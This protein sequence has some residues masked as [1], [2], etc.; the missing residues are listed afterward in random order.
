MGNCWYHHIIF[1]FVTVKWYQMKHLAVLASNITLLPGSFSFV[2]YFSL[3]FTMRTQEGWIHRLLKA[4]KLSKYLSSNSWF[5]TQL[6]V[7]CLHSEFHNVCCNV[8]AYNSFRTLCSGGEL[9]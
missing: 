2:I 3:P 5:D 6:F 9:H 4:V 1:L 7:I 8:L